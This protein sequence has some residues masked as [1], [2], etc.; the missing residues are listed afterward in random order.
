MTTTEQLRGLH[1]LTNRE[2]VKPR[3]LIEVLELVIQGGAS[4]IQLRDK[5]VPKEDMIILGRELR[6]IT[7]NKCFLIV[8][9]NIDVALEIGADGIHVGQKDMSARGVRNLIP[10]NM[11]LGV[12]AN[13]V[14]EALKAEQDGANYIG[15]G[16]VF[17]TISK[18][19]ADSPIGLSGLSAIKQAVHI[20]VIAIGGISLQN[21]ADVAK[22]SDGIAIIS[23]VLRAEDPKKATEALSALIKK[24]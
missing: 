5:N 15:A 14:N 21:A 2:A 13:T 4:V 8:N 17:P 18:F 16:P 10:S 1:V 20:P 24:S 7:Q 12:S 22:I 11:I 9:D 19:D 3:P 6:K 23:A